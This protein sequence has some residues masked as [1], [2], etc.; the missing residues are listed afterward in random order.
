MTYD[1]I[2]ISVLGVITAP[3]EQMRKAGSENGHMDTHVD[4]H[5]SAHT[6]TRTRRQVSG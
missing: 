6:W 4:T 2:V 5:M 3:T 1:P